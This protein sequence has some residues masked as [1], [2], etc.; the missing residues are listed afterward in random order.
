MKLLA[1]IR[2]I[3]SH[4]CTSL[5]PHQRNK[6][7]CPVGRIHRTDGVLLPIKLVELRQVYGSRT[8]RPQAAV[9]PLAQKYAVLHIRFVEAFSLVCPKI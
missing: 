8:G 2:T 6:R 3:F 7:R 1:A 4:I 9:F 5:W